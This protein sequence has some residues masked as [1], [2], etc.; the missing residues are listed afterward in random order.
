ME[1]TTGKK[2]DP[3]VFKVFTKHVQASKVKST[4]Q[5][6]MADSFDPSVPYA[7]LPLEEV[8]E[9]FTDKDF[10]QIRFLDEKKDKKN[11]KDKK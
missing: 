2:L 10:G 11:K 9:M 7:E 5:L 1:K 3:K 4:K 8:E 6:R